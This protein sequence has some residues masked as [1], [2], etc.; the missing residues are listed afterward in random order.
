MIKKIRTLKFGKMLLVLIKKE[1][2]YSPIS[3]HIP[4]TALGAYVSDWSDC[5]DAMC[6]QKSLLKLT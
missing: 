5:L 4:T 6:P 2:T 1:C 3:K